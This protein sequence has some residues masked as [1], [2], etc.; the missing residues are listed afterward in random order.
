MNIDN[1]TFNLLVFY[2]VLALIAVAG[3]LIAVASK[4]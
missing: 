1:Q 2:G 3:A 4:K